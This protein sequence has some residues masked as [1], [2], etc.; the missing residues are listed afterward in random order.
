MGSHGVPRLKS[1]Y[2][3]RE[4]RRTVATFHLQK[5]SYM[6]DLSPRMLQEE[7]FQFPSRGVQRDLHV[8]LLW[9]VRA[10]LFHRVFYFPSMHDVDCC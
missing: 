10:T 7:I 2:R 1:W 4:W 6:L 5:D 9:K 8:I 3:H